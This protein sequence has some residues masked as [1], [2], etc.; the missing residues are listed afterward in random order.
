[1]FKCSKLEHLYI[2]INKTKTFE[3]FNIDIPDNEN[4]IYDDIK[5]TSLF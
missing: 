5:S 2:G 1:M 4:S 3:T